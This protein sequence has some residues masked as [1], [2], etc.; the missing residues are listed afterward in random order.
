MSYEEW[1]K[2]VNEE[3]RLLYGTD[4]DGIDDWD[5]YNAWLDGLRP[6]EAASQAFAAACENMGLIL[7]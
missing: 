7:D 2:K 6:I 5:Y 3:L 4:A 1:K